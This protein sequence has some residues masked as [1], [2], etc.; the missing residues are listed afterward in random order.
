MSKIKIL[1]I[2]NDDKFIDAA[3][4]LYEKAFPNSN[5]VI[6]TIPDEINYILKYIKN[7]KYLISKKNK[8]SI[9]KIK[10]E[11]E[12]HDIVVFHSYDDFKAELIEKRNIKKFI[13]VVWGYEIYTNNFK[14]LYN[15]FEKETLNYI[16]KNNSYIKKKLKPYYYIVKSFFQIL[17]D[18]K[19]K[20]LKKIKYVAILHKE[21]FDLFRKKNIINK[22]AKHCIFT[23]YPIEFIFKQNKDNKISG[24]N[25]LIGNSATPTNNHLDIFKKLKD[26]DLT[27]KQIIL[28]LSYGNKEYGKYIS[29]QANTI[30]NDVRPLFDFMPLNEYNK[31]LQSCNILIMN[32]I[33]QQGV[34]NI[35][36]GLWL[37]SKVFLNKKNTF[38]KYL[39]RIGCIVFSL[40]ELDN[41][42]LNSLTEEQIKINR[43]ILS[44]EIGEKRIINEIINDLNQ[45]KN[46]Q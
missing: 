7:D 12:E 35:L 16:E 21:D 28:P 13:Y 34:G 11:I 39:K 10:N 42:N 5:K 9:A 3:Y 2:T 44:N 15:N 1:H 38:Y 27:G 46:N 40:D 8:E 26:L 36:A 4:Y 17:N 45:I 37:G 31:L 30:F 32:H 20:K 29:K 33:R 6:V 18:N 23:Y 41:N 22:N 14:F 24:N 43:T 19:F 25:I